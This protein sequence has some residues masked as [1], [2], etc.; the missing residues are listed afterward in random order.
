[1]RDTDRTRDRMG[2]IAASL[3]LAL[4]VFLLVFTLRSD[5]TRVVTR[6]GT[7]DAV[8]EVEERVAERLDREGP[9]TPLRGAVRIIASDVRWD[10]PAGVPW[11]RARQV[12][13]LLAGEALAGDRVVLDEVRL[14][15]ADVRLRRSPGGAWNFERALREGGGRDDGRRAGPGTAVVL[16]DV[17]IG[18]SVVRV[19][20]G[21]DSYRFASVNAS[22]P[23]A[24]LAGAGAPHV[25]LASLTSSVSANDGPARSLRVTGG[26]VRGDGSAVVFT[27]ERLALEDSYVQNV[28]GVWSPDLTAPGIRA[29]GYA[30]R[31]NFADVHALFP[32]FPETGVAA[33]DWRVEPVGGA[34][35]LHLSDIDM[36]SGESS[37][38]GAL[39]VI[40]GGAEPRLGTIDLRLDPVQLAFLEELL[41]TPLPYSGTVT[42]AVTGSG[43]LLR[44]DLD[45]LLRTEG[46]EGVIDAGLQGSLSLAGLTPT[47]QRFAVE[48]RE[49]SLAALRG[50]VPGL[51]L[52]GEL[53]GTITFQG[54]PGEG[55]ARIDGELQVA[56]GRILLDGTVTPSGVPSYNLSGR[57]ED[58]R[59][60]RILDPAAPPVRLDAQ[61]SLQ[62]RG[63]SP[64]TANASLRLDGRFGGWQAGPTDIVALRADLQGG[65][66]RLE[67]MAL[68]L[69]TLQLTASGDWRF[70]EP[71]AGGLQ[72]RMQVESLDPWAPYLPG[73][74][75]AADGRLAT[76][77]TLS[78]P[79]HTLRLAGDFET[80]DLRYGGWA[81]TRA[82]LGYDLALTDS[83][84]RIQAEGVARGLVTPAFGNYERVEL[85]ADMRRPDFGF[86]LTADQVGGGVL[87]VV[88]EGRMP[89]GSERDLVLQHMLVDLGE[90]RW[91][92][93]RPAGIR[94]QDGDV[95]VDSLLVANA[96]GPGTF[97][98]DGQVLP[99]TEAQAGFRI[100]ALPVA[101]I[102]R[103]T[104]R[105]VI[106]RGR[107]WASGSVLAVDG[108]PTFDVD[109]Q[110][111]DASA[112]GIRFA[113]L[114]GVVRFDGARLDIDG[115]G[116]IADPGGSFSVDAIIPI[117]LALE[118]SVDIGIGEA[119]RV[120]GRITFDDLPLAVAERVSTQ[121][122]DTEGW[123]SGTVELGGTAQDPLLSGRLDVR[124]GAVT[125]HAL[126]Q[127][128][129][130]ITGAIVLNGQRAR[131]ENFVVRSGG[132]ARLTGGLVFDELDNPV[133][134]VTV[135]LDGFR[136]I[137]IEDEDEVGAWG[138][139]T[140]DGPLRA[141]V[142]GGAVRVDDGAIQVPGGG[143]DPLSADVTEL[144]MAQN[145]V[146]IEDMPGTQPPVFGDLTVQGLVID[147]GDDLWFVT[148]EARAELTGE[149]TVFHSAGETRLFGTLEGERGTFILR[150]GPFLRRFE[151]QSAAIRF[152]GTPDLNPALDV[153]ATRVVGG[154]VGDPVELVVNVGGTVERPTLSMT[155]GAGVPVPESQ[156]LSYLVFGRGDIGTFADPDA[157]SALALG[158]APFS[159]LLGY[160]IQQQAD[161]IDYLQIRTAEGTDPLAFENLAVSIGTEAFFDD[162][163]VTF[164][165]PLALGSDKY[166]VGVEWRIDPEWTVELVWEPLVWR[167]AFGSVEL[168]EIL[169][170]TS[171]TTRQFGLDVKRRW[172]Y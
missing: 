25:R 113:E 103:L 155:S 30:P 127:R 104:S 73:A 51:P 172:T 159:D 31:V 53:T 110:V 56:G 46:V 141:P 98:V 39:T 28:Q 116:V 16:R 154:A 134:D 135:E 121:I 90:E 160:Y 71:A 45:A 81:A 122:S 48:L 22:L 15:G 171:G 143:S 34:L 8:R 42:G 75:S 60:D 69:A 152:F 123:L 80:S 139:I 107:L 148:K 132:T 24:R 63:A 76:T 93:E 49:T 114:G 40:I 35:A 23:E 10:D 4:A 61:F 18:G 115:R 146:E 147:A 133:A 12:S 79:L 163:F 77:G 47:I 102:Q 66:L 97:F 145:A 83:L 87:Q 119:G 168:S 162:V 65:T 43:D 92:L 169:T 136:P 166:S 126:D 99:L 52:A 1:M 50:L 131:F 88:A 5:D 130:G 64:S 89:P 170:S 96:G 78:G 17:R 140:L 85:S 67:R 7:V 101:E 57:I 95:S 70:V 100:E 108:L 38:G 68:R 142:V 165:V 26:V 118:D 106:V 151:I 9:P 144:T 158:Y 74:S 13:G 109:F 72:Y 91:A 105:D 27:A 6:T 137:G 120:D 2:I 54:A 36:R 84:P 150:A 157:G 164:D 138:T 37:I 111:D 58:I 167:R 33:F 44:F 21:D 153:T 86:R 59:L 20:L 19:A 117:E 14:Q 11:L 82:E 29:R 125:V 41:G 128:Y 62:G 149:L 32:A 3:A 112:E 156:L 124:D 161:W 129:D 55:P 94:W